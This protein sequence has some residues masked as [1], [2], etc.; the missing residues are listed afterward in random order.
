MNIFNPFF[1]MDFCFR[2]APMWMNVVAAAIGVASTVAF[3]CGAYL[4]AY[5]RDSG[6][7]FGFSMLA[8]VAGV[9]WYALTL[10]VAI[11]VKL[12]E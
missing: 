3:F 10:L 12:S 6:G 4:V 11:L 1:I 5:N 9:V 2:Y 7:T 8:F